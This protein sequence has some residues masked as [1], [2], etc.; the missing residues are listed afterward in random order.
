ME[1]KYKELLRA[2]RDFQEHFEPKSYPD[3]EEFENL[4]TKLETYAEENGFVWYW[5]GQR[6]YL[7]ECQMDFELVSTLAM[8]GKTNRYDREHNRE[9]A[10]PKMLFK[11]E[12]P[13][14][15]IFNSIEDEPQD[16]HERSWT[17]AIESKFLLPKVCF[18]DSKS[19]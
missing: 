5:N 13:G 16:S 6:I 14:W 8:L 9:K 15:Y 3:E 18:Y 7:A 10:Y 4:Y 1:R 17:L 12:G 2:L 11:Y 19:K